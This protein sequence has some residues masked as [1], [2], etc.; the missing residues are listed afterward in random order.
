[1]PLAQ[2]A[3]KDQRVRL[4]TLRLSRVTKAPWVRRVIPVPLVPLARRGLQGLRSISRQI[5]V[6]KVRKARPGPL[7]Q[8]DRQVRLVLRE[9]PASRATMVPMVR[10]G[11]RVR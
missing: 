5:R 4:S 9:R 10:M 6:T 11:L 8:P 7:V 3:G 2:Q 1:M